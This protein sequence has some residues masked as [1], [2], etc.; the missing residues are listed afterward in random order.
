MTVCCAES[1]Q[2]VV[3]AALPEAMT[4]GLPE[5][6]GALAESGARSLLRFVEGVDAVVVGPGLGTAPGTVALLERLLSGAPVPVVAD[7]DALNAFAGRPALLRE[8]AQ[9]QAP[10]S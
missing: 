2:D 10:R 3:V 7:A 5:A 1:L 6:G 8:E 4:L 9:G